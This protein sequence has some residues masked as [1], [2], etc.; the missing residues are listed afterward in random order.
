[1]KFISI[2]N[3]A[4]TATAWRHAEYDTSELSHCLVYWNYRIRLSLIHVC[5]PNKI[6]HLV[7]IFQNY[8]SSSFS[9]PRNFSLRINWLWCNVWIFTFANC[10]FDKRTDWREEKKIKTNIGVSTNAPNKL[11]TTIY[12]TLHHR[13][14]GYHLHVSRRYIN[15]SNERSKSEMQIAGFTRVTQKKKKSNL[16]QSPKRAQR[17]IEHL[18]SSAPLLRSGNFRIRIR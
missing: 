17:S 15:R 16:Y 10:L 2:W 12:S 7:R 13:Q 5:S 6:P 3:C 14:T 9:F 8:D 11:Q 1:M 18:K 4:K